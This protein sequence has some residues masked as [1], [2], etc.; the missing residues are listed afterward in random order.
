[1]NRNVG[2]VILVLLAVIGALTVI[3]AVVRALRWLLIL[4]VVVAVLSAL[5]GAM[6]GSSK[7]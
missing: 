1:V 4:A 6:R 2:M 7:D 3:G 5:W